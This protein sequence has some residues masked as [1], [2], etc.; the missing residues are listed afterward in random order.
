MIRTRTLDDSRNAASSAAQTPQEFTGGATN[1]PTER[2]TCGARGIPIAVRPGGRFHRPGRI[3]K[4]S[5][6]LVI[7]VG[8]AP[9]A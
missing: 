6:D 2:L 3:P 8:S 9:A 7:A 1:Q 4:A 5:C